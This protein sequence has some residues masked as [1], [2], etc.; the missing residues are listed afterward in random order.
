M[1]EQLTYNVRHILNGAEPKINDKWRL[2][3]HECMPL[4]S[5]WDTIEILVTYGDLDN[6][7]LTAETREAMAHINLDST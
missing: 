5:T 2:W 4:G 3:F 7:V 1:V 6:L